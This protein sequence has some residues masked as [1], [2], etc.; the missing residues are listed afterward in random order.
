MKKPMVV[1]LI[2]KRLSKCETSMKVYRYLDPTVKEDI[3]EPTNAEVEKLISTIEKATLE[4][5][6]SS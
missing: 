3:A 5:A 1:T 6:S 2:E 4:I